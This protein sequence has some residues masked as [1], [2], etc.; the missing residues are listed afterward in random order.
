MFNHAKLKVK[1]KKLNLLWSRVFGLVLLNKTIEKMFNILPMYLTG[2]VA[3]IVLFFFFC[4]K[5]ITKQGFR[6]VS[7]SPAMTEILFALGSQ[8]LLAG[9][10][11][12][13]D[14]PEAAKKIPK[15]G[16]FSNP[17]IERIVGLKP[18]LVIVN[19]PEQRRIKQELE[20][21][22]IQVFVS[23]PKLLSDIYQEIEKL[24]K[25]IKKERQ[26]DS[27][28]DNLKTIIKPVN[29]SKKRIYIELSPRPI[30]TAGGKTFLNELVQIAGGKNIF[31]DLDK[32]YPVVSQEEIIKRNPEII[33]LLH[34]EDVGD[35]IG[36]QKISAIKNN[37]VYKNLNPDHLLRPGPRLILGF[38]ALEKIFE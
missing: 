7:L 19:L 14:Y 25:I 9:N 31:S 37:K 21:L 30:I 15:V 10:T 12:Y 32:D 35:R 23:S 33:I 28:T 26:A 17:S 38:K 20:K 34:P 3:I 24:G 27:L 16:D 36:W 2:L 5:S 6:I 1:N 8:D 29:R 18:D 11:T 13:C 22:N 4:E